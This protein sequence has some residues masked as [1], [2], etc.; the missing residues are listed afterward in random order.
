M[1]SLVATQKY[2]ESFV[3]FCQYITNKWGT[4]NVQTH[5]CSFPSENDQPFS[6]NILAYRMQ[7]NNKSRHTVLVVEENIVS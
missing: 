6:Y 7:G 3:L 2:Y 5:N 4:R 1:N